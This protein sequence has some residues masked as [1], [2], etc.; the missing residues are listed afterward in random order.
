MQNDIWAIRPATPADETDLASP[1]LGCGLFSEEEAQGFL[2]MIPDQLGQAEHLWWVAAQ[3]RVR[4]AAYA[5]RDGMSEDVWNLWFIGF[6]KA[7]QGQGGGSRLMERLEADIAKEGR[8]I[9]VIETASSMEA[10]Q[11]F[12]AGRGYREQGRIA[13]YYGPGEAK[14]IFA[15]PLT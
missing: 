11:R 3:D 5:T 10:T 2:G 1:I 15:R 8:R 9:L 12:Y 7:A 13:D 4:G 14:V 6:D